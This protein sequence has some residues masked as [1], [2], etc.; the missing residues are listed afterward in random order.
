M[1][2]GTDVARYSRAGAFLARRWKSALL[3]MAL[4]QSIYPL[5][6]I[7]ISV[8]ALIVWIFAFCTLGSIAFQL[9]VAIYSFIVA[10]KTSS[11]VPTGWFRWYGI[12]GVAMLYAV[13]A[14]T[15]VDLYEYP[16]ESYSI[17]SDS[18]RPSLPEGDRLVAVGLYGK[19][20]ERGE[21]VI[22]RRDD[23]G[24]TH[25]IK[26]VVAIAGDS[27]ELR[28]NRLSINDQEVSRQT[29]GSLELNWSRYDVIEEAMGERLYS[30]LVK[31]E[32]TSRAAN[33][34]PRIV[35]AGHVFVLGDNRDNSEDSRFVGT[36]RVE[37][38]HRRAAFVFWS[39]DRDRIGLD[40][41]KSAR[42]PV[43]LAPAN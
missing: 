25:Y 36:I 33:F 3:V 10:R 42:R 16:V 26:R 9:G 12:V 30:V 1:A 31:P 22:F 6:A 15:V 13:A 40:L 34:G 11:F 14:T 37:N 27:I 2:G 35:P 24:D 29:V 18:M 21:I 38:I 28:N 4:I 7:L 19:S 8:D 32:S 5:I 43:S 39:R 20:I 23:S 17:P 41:R